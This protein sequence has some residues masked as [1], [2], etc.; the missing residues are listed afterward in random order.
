[1]FLSGICSFVLPALIFY[2]I[3]QNRRDAEITRLEEIK[4]TDPD[5]VGDI[6]AK[7][8]D[9]YEFKQINLWELFTNYALQ[10]L[11]IISFINLFN[12]P[13]PVEIISVFNFLNTNKLGIN[14]NAT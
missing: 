9:T 13:N 14:S 7:L 11:F 3:R 4:K 2:A 8:E 5:S 6:N 12:Q 1:L 10:P